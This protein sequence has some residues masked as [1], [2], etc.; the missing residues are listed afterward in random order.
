[1]C[2]YTTAKINKNPLGGA[3]L[4][5]TSQTWHFQSAGYCKTYQRLKHSIVLQLLYPS[6][7]DSV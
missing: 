4:H 7:V 5:G 1:M 3:G 2:I 6:G